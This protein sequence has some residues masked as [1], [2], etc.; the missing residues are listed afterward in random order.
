MAVALG[1]IGRPRGFEPHSRHIFIFYPL[2]PVY[3]MNMNLFDLEDIVL[4]E[5]VPLILLGPP[6]PEN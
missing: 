3:P 1:A 4:N 2:S 6:N 5:M